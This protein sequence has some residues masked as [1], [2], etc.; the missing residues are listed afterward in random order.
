[1]TT[2]LLVRHG[3][4]DPVGKA[5][6][7]RA[8]AIHLNE[9]GRAQAE[10]LARR[11]GH[12]PLDAVYSGPLERARE[13][14]EP[15]AR[16][17]GVQV[18]VVDELDEIDFGEWTGRALAELT[19]QPAWRRFNSL[20]SLTRVPAG[21]LMLE[22][23]ARTV[24]ALEAIRRVHPEGRCAVFS[25]GDVIRSVMA[26]YAGIPLDLAYRLAVEPASVSVLRVWD[27]GVEIGCI[28]SRGDL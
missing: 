21:E 3:M 17:L 2:Y 23:Q 15:L 20:R 7:G 13:T 10:E 11:L 27:D 8:P 4:C 1:M 14:A 16:R 28:N 12:V 19:P 24:T 6:A 18:R 22:V 25:H 5:I 26:H 9:Q